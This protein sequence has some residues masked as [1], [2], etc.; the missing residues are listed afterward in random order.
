MVCPACGA[1]NRG[2][3]RFC[4]EC[5]HAFQ[6]VCP[7][8]GAPNPPGRAFCDQCGVRL[9]VAPPGSLPSARPVPH[10]PEGGLAERRVVTVLFADLVGFTTLSESR[11]AEEVRELLSR[12]FDSCRRLIALYGGSVE[13]FIGDAVMAVWGTPVARED[14]PER[15]V[16]AALELVAAV[17]ALGEEV[18]APDL[19]ARAG[20][21]TGEA[22]VTIG[23]VGEGMVAGDLVNTASRV[24]SEA[25]PGTVLVGESTKRSTQ[26]A[27]DYADAG[28]RQLKGKVEPV[29]LFQALRVTGGR[30]GARKGEAAEPPF[31][32]RDRELRLLKELYHGSAD[33][34]KAHLVSVTGI[35]G[36]GKSRLA[37]EFFKYLDGLV[38]DAWWWRGRCLAYGEGVTYWALAEMIRMR[39][40]IVEGEPAVTARPKLMEALDPY[41]K[42]P[43]ER[44]WIEPRLAQLV[45]L[46]EGAGERDDLFAAWRLYFE[47]LSEHRPAVLVF[48]D[49]QWADTSLLEF[50][51]YL[52]EWSRSY[53]IF[54]LTLARPELA[55]RHPN[56]SVGKRNF[57]SVFLEPL[58][59]AAMQALL[60]GFA[61]GLPEELRERILERAEGVPLYA[62]ETVRML[63]DRGL[64]ELSGDVYRPTGAIGALEVPETLHALVAARLDGLSAPEREVL[65]RAAVLGKT[66]SRQALAALDGESDAETEKLLAGLVRKEVLTVQGDARS[67]E[68]GQFTFLQDLLRQV[69]YETLSRHRRRELHV[70]A[71][72]FL[73]GGWGPAESEIAEIVASHYLAAVEAD[74]GA[75]DAAAIGDRARVMLI[76]AGERASS[77]AAREEAGRYFEQAAELAVDPV[78]KAG[79]LERAGQMA[80]AST[81]REHA[82]AQFERAL[83]LFKE[84]G[85]S[86]Q[87]ARV[88]SRL[89]EV[90]WELGRLDEALERMEA[91]FAEFQDVEPDADIA[92]VAAGLGRLHAFRGNWEL[93]L[94]RVNT[95]LQVAETLWL[96]EILCSALISKGTIATYQSRPQEGIALTRHALVL[97]LEHELGANALR[98]I[99]N[100]ADLLHRHDACADA[101]EQ[102]EQGLA[103]ARRLGERRQEYRLAAELSWSLVVTGRWEQALEVR[104]QVEGIEN[105]F[106]MALPA[107]F[108]ARGRPAQARAQLQA[109]DAGSSD[110]QIR[111]GYHSGLSVVL[112]AEGSRQEALAA[113]Q[114]ALLAWDDLGPASQPVKV[115]LPQ[116]L[117]AAF[118]LGEAALIEEL[119]QRIEALP[120]GELAPSVRGIGFRFRARAA[121]AA[122]DGKAAERA[123]TS[124]AKTFRDI[125]WPFWLAMVLT[126]QGEWL[127][128]EGRVGEAAPLLA[129][130]A[131]VF[132][133]L[134]AAVWL[135]RAQ[136]GAGSPQA[137]TSL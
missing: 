53:P 127:A 9:A 86:H 3:A 74:P 26:A 44:A 88:A 20:V 114:E 73:E 48:E 7:G 116:A 30:G 65:Q 29:P 97:A 98:A 66:F 125:G 46:E 119:L 45:G 59:S 22:A 25:E 32:G 122:G 136:A 62:V 16:R 43:E 129:E 15:A 27:V 33:E 63:L 102:L 84:A 12:Y 58:P 71:A 6:A 137:V 123:F 110:I 72:E 61:P 68:R 81:R 18:G 82:F 92:A 87:A 35:A 49:V 113:A 17:S 75:A 96:P 54:V 79:L 130:A 78:E 100:L 94:S 4:F 37:W 38:E 39:A 99:N 1:E 36:I 69:A 10:A 111:T 67:P 21:V 55:D 117:E 28:A 76:R 121:I 126:E 77:L 112:N 108:V 134:G 93:S 40:D 105:V 47:R 70:A 103:L 95:A 8:C 14:D 124:A 133:K 89:G 50:I 118:A 132:E 128:G 101:A 120:P 85:E 80:L 104:G 60:D 19:R 83:E 135:E 31:V 42:D 51:E 13:K 52:L 34:R 11:D 107:V 23:A 64:V 5:G 2:E 41:V 109:E 56:W 91:A 24:Q 57:S 90:E 115:A 131:G 106:S